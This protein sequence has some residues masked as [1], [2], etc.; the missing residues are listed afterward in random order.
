[1]QEEPIS[2]T[3]TKK[4]DDKGYAVG[5]LNVINGS[6][7]VIINNFKMSPLDIMIFPE[8][9]IPLT[10][11]FLQTV[12]QKPEAF[13][14]IDGGKKKN[15]QALFGTQNALQFSPINEY[16]QGNTGRAVRDAVKIASAIDSLSFV[17]PEDAKDLLE[18]LKE[19]S[20]RRAYEE[21]GT[22]EIFA[23]IA[24][25]AKGHTKQASFED[26]I[27]QLD[28]DRQFVYSDEHGNYFVKQANSGLNKTWTTK[29][30]SMDVYELQDMITNEKKA[31]KFEKTASFFSHTPV[32]DV[33]S[34]K[35]VEGQY[36][37]VFNG[38]NEVFD[39]FYITSF[40]KV[41]ET[42]KFA[43]FSIA[44]SQKMLYIGKN[45]EYSVKTGS[46]MVPVKSKE[47]AEYKKDGKYYVA[48][49]TNS[50]VTPEM[51]GYEKVNDKKSV[52][53]ASTAV[54]FDSLEGSEPKI[55]SFGVFVTESHA[56][57]P[58]EVTEIRKIAGIGGY[59]VVGDMGL[60]KMAFYPIKVKNSEFTPHDTE[61]NAF[62][63]PGNAKFIKLA[64][65]NDKLGALQEF[66]AKIKIEGLNGFTKEAFYL[67]DG[68]SEPENKVFNLN[69]VFL[70]KKAKVNGKISGN[71]LTHSVERDEHGFFS[72]RGAEF[73]KYA[74][75]SPIRNLSL[76]EAQWSAIHC[77]AT[78][79]DVV[80][81]ASMRP[82]TTVTLEGEVKSPAPVSLFEKSFNEKYASLNDRKLKIAKNLVKQAAEFTDKNTVDAVLSIGLLR[83]R[84]LQEYLAM[85]PTYEA[86]LTEL[87]KLLMASRMGMSHVSP[88][89]AKDAMDAMAQLIME[90]YALQAAISKVK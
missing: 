53:T 25:K 15:Y 41:A 88:D 29:I 89:S 7:P 17:H 48:L 1:M 79:E 56:T 5:S 28:I 60:T 73:D 52:K 33:N 67:T 20:V 18:P 21:N 44:D 42:E 83:R 63:V 82:R 45:S 9:T 72:L 70:T 35:D 24:E 22:I 14:G 36:F 27:R 43:A 39:D 11:Y 85:L 80:K 32:G 49:S 61:K 6:V 40:E 86:T 74:Q 66:E 69:D 2:V 46:Y 68:Q 10:D 23:K 31:E 13:K 12:F 76:L 19:A 65:H 71:P 8:M 84:N 37:N 58:F 26:A 54:D 4:D 50:K 62:W 75:E 47:K 38:E 77:G 30:D 90:L 34:P 57:E 87:A 3:W 55:G 78:Q 51:E 59:K 64:G 16:G 81:I